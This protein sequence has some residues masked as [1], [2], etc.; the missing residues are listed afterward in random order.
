MTTTL[1]Q[2]K[3]WISE[4]IKSGSKYYY[5]GQSDSEW[6]LITSF[7]RSSIGKGITLNHYLTEIMI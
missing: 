1:I 6:G 2:Y 5:R 7:H 3:N 4:S